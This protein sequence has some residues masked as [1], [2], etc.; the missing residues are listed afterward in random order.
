MARCFV[1]DSQGQRLPLTRGSRLT[2]AKLD[3][4]VKLGAPGLLNRG[5]GCADS[6]NSPGPFVDTG[7]TVDCVPVTAA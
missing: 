3:E 7:C 2:S 4:L 5:S 1:T 6:F